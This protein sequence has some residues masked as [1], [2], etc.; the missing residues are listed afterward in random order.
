MGTDWLA[1]PSLSV[2]LHCLLFFLNDHD[3]RVHPSVCHSAATA[4]AAAVWPPL[5]KI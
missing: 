2:S 4:A 3:E 1:V 5:P